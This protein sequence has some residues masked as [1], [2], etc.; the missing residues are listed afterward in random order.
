MSAPSTPELAPGTVVADRYEVARLLGDGSPGQVYLAIQHP[1]EREVV[2]KIVDTNPH[3]PRDQ[4]RFR[5]EAEALSR[6]SHPACIEV[7]DYGQWT[8]WS[9]LALIFVPG[10]QLSNRLPPSGRWDLASALDLC[11]DVADGLAHAHSVGVIHRNLSPD[12]IVVTEQRGRR[13]SAQMVDFGFAHIG[14]VDLDTTAGSKPMGT[15]GYMAPERIRGQ[16]GDPRADVFALGVIL[17]EMLTGTHPFRRARSA[18]TLAATATERV[19]RLSDVHPAIDAPPPVIEALWKAT[20]PDP[21]Q[22]FANGDELVH[23]LR[24]ARASLPST[25]PSPPA[26]GHP[27]DLPPLGV[28]PVQDEPT[29]APPPP[30]LDPSSPRRSSWGT[31]AAIVVVLCLV[32]GAG[33]ITLGVLVGSWLAQQ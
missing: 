2:L 25:P 3:D 9:Y 16:P 20:S 14:R 17:F 7:I 29:S 22:R 23:A 4:A 15:P 28:D 27:T 1:L 10:P 8:Q 31:T 30:P 33:T 18:D 32:G 11:I 24:E 21:E 13:A 12:R 5:R 26:V 6:L 19:P